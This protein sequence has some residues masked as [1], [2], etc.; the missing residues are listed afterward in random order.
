MHS[1]TVVNKRLTWTNHFK[2]HVGLHGEGIF[3]FLNEMRGNFAPGW[4][5]INFWNA[6]GRVHVDLGEEL[7]ELSILVM[8]QWAKPSQVL[9]IQAAVSSVEDAKGLLCHILRD[10]QQKPVKYNRTYF[11]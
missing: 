5:L 11:T 2:S 1:H 8:I 7:G 4:K 3:N 9:Q 6:V 10:L